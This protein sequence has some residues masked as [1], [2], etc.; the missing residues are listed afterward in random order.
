LILKENMVGTSSWAT[1]KARMPREI[2]YTTYRAGE[3]DPYLQHLMMLRIRCLMTYPFLCMSSLA[4]ERATSCPTTRLCIARCK[5]RIVGLAIG[6]ALNDYNVVQEGFNAA[7]KFAAALGDD[8]A[9]Y[10][11]M[12]EIYVEPE[13]RHD[14]VGSCL[15]HELNELVAAEG[16]YT[17][18]S[19]QS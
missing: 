13:Y 2:T 16:I 4:E 10:F 18:L 11:L 15:I 3:T 5:D 8:L 1:E 7:E 19:A 17:E 12:S 9:R 14:G 6:L